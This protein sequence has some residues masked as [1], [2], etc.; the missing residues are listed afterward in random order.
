MLG[1]WPQ[2]ELPNLADDNCDVVSEQKNRYNCI[3]WTAGDNTKWWWP[4]QEKGI[5]YWPKKGTAKGND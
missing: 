4:S 2:N 1:N 3:A 5:S